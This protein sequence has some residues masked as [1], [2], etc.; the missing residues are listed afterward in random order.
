MNQDNL[1]FS[2]LRFSVFLDSGFASIKS[3]YDLL[4]SQVNS[5]EEY[6]VSFDEFF[7]DWAQANWELLV[8]RAVCG[9][10]ESLNTYGSGSDYEMGIH[11]RVFF[12]DAVSTHHIKCIAGPEAIDHLTKNTIDLSDF[13]FDSLVSID[14]DWYA[15]KPPFN[16]ALLYKYGEPKKVG[17][18]VVV[19]TEQTAVV[20]ISELQFIAKEY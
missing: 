15:I 2:I 7:D 3:A 6:V 14:Q 1:Q 11:S 9:I 5:P 16:Y 8:E 19:P 4:S 13:E 17:E 18:N 10:N 20:K 12:H